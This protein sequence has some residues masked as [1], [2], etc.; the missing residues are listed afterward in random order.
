MAQ[1]ILPGLLQLHIK[2]ELPEDFKILGVSRRDWDDAKLREHISA[3]LGGSPNLTPFLDRITF[4]QGDIVDDTLFAILAEQIGDKSAILYFSL[5][6]ALYTDAFLRLT[7]SPLREKAQQLRLMIEKPFGTDAMSAK[8]LQKILTTTFDESQLYRVDHYLA[9]EALIQLPQTDHG[10]LKQIEVYFMERDGVEGRGEFYDKVGALRDVGQNHIL[11]MLA[12]ALGKANRVEMLEG[13]H[14]LMSNEIAEGTVRGQY[15]HYLQ[16]RGVDPNSTTE[17]YFKI[18]TTYQGIQI[19]LEGGK[20][21]GLNRKEI[22]FT[23]QNGSAHVLTVGSNTDRSEYERLI[24]ECIRGEK[25]LFV[26]MREVDALWRFIDPILHAW[27]KD[28]VP[29]K[30]YPLGAERV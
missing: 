21:L 9:K 26:S 23:H 11:E 24:L 5:S 7:E 22:I 2:D 3:A 16:T 13:L 25:T 27:D 6:P 10:V 18:K 4:V 29:L 15:E 1:K 12:V 30:S 19:V 28:S 17:T 20:R 8:E 14:V